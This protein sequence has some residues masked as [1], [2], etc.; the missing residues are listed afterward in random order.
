MIAFLT[1]WGF[2]LTVAFS[3]Y[4]EFYTPAAIFVFVWFGLGASIILELLEQ[5]FQKKQAGT[6]VLQIVASILLIA[7]PLLQSREISIS[8]ITNGYTTFVRRDHIYPIFAPDKAIRDAKKITNR[9]EDDAI[10]FTDWDKLYSYIYTA[11][12]EEGRTGIAFHEATITD[13]PSLAQTTLAYIDA[14]ID[15]RPIYFTVFMPELT[16]RYQVQQINNTLYRI[17]RK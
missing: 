11:H 5:I 16:E 14:N 13:N 17:H 8:A 10:V 3:V 12:I 4:Q 1:I 9:I 6:W 15:V 2:A 7:L